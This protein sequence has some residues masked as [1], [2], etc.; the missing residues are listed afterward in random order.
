MKLSEFQHKH[1]QGLYIYN[2]FEHENGAF[3]QVHVRGGEYVLQEANGE[4]H[5]FYSMEAL[6]AHVEG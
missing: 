5:T 3:I 1:V 6:K 4:R 2:H